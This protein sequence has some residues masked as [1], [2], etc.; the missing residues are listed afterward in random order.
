MRIFFV[1]I[2]ILKV[3]RKRKREIFFVV[4]IFLFSFAVP[5]SCEGHSGTEKKIS[6]KEKRFLFQRDFCISKKE[7]RN[8]SM[9]KFAGD[10]YEEG[11]EKFPAGE[12]FSA[13]GQSI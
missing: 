12:N 6:E 8:K 4:V 7:K 2:A 13:F 1:V 3:S 9:R 5:A 10:F 11:K